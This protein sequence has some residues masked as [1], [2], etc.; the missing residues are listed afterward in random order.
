MKLLTKLLFIF[1]FLTVVTFSQNKIIKQ[2]TFGGEVASYTLADARLMFSQLDSL[3]YVIDS[4]GSLNFL[5]IL[6]DSLGEKI[7]SRRVIIKNDD[8]Y[9]LGI[10]E[11]EIYNFIEQKLKLQKR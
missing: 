1:I 7:F 9:K 8:F 5:I 10:K 3:G 4:T 2:N 11:K 6:Q